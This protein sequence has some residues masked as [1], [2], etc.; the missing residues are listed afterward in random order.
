MR[1]RAL[2]LPPDHTASQLRSTGVLL[3]A[4]KG[5]WDAARAELSAIPRR[6]LKTYARA[7]TCLAES[8]LDAEALFREHPPGKAMV[9]Q[10]WEWLQAR[11]DEQLGPE[12][13]IRNSPLANAIFRQGQWALNR[14]ARQYQVPAWR[15]RQPRTWRRTSLRSRGSGRR[16][17][18]VLIAISA[19]IRACSHSNQR[20]P[21]RQH[22]PLHR[23]SSQDAFRPSTPTLSTGHGLHPARRPDV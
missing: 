13:S 22:P 14:L 5:E 7:A 2:R 19:L 10:H 11:V 18:A 16:L 20:P 15:L 17:F 4:S 23:S 9:R 3:L 6:A 8:V 12:T 1:Q 21:D